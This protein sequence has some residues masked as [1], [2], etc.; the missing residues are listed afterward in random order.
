MKIMSHTESPSRSMTRKDILDLMES[1]EQEYERDIEEEHRKLLDMMWED[2]EERRKWRERG[3][4]YI[5]R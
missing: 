5:L 2:R 3:D 4:T 1:I